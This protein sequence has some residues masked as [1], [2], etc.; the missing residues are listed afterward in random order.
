VSAIHRTVKALRAELASVRAKLDKTRQ[1]HFSVCDGG[2]CPMCALL[3]EKKPAK[4][5]KET[6]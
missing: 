3:A 5:K 2:T 6:P 4:K 1:L